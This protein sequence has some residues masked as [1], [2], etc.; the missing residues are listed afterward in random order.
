MF[1]VVV[2]VAICSQS[3]GGEGD[4]YEGRERLAVTVMVRVQRRG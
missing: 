4:E 3:N 2:V 1:A